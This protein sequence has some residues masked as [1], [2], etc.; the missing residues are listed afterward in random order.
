MKRILLSAAALAIAPLATA[1]E[2]EVDYSEDFMESLEEDYGEREGEYLSREVAEDLQRAFEKAGLDP[3]RVE[4]TILKATP[5]RPTM[6]QLGDQPGLDFGR[7]IG[8]GGMK[9]AATAYDEAGAETASLEYGWFENDIRQVIGTA[10]W[11]DANTASRRFA[12]KFVKEL[13][14]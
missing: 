13:E 8:I 14:E 2:I 4:V 6:K 3:A 9:L 7:S 12:R 1:A 11:S 5:N 10:T